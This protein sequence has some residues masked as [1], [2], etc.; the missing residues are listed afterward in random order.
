MSKQFTA[1]PFPEKSTEGFHL[2][3][4]FFGLVFLGWVIGGGRFQGFYIIPDFHP[5]FGPVFW[6]NAW[7]AYGLGALCVCG[8]LAGVFQK[9]RGIGHSIAM[10]GFLGLLLSD[11]IAYL[12]TH[13][14]V[15]LML[16]TS[17]ILTFKPK[18]VSIAK[19]MF[20]LILVLGIFRLGLDSLMA[21]N[22]D[23]SLTPHYPDILG[24]V[25]ILGY[26]F[27]WISKQ[28]RPEI[29]SAWLS[30]ALL[31]IPVFLFI[32][33]LLQGPLWIARTHYF[34]WQ[35]ASIPTTWQ[36]HITLTPTDEKPA[37]LVNSSSIFGPYTGRIACDPKI[38]NAYIAYV[39]QKAPTWW[40]LSIRKGIDD[41]FVSIG[42]GP[43]QRY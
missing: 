14:L 16:C 30:L 3:T 28:K 5:G 15:V 29:F 21:H 4:T 43:S 19:W 13:F 22:L 10:F 37:I 33:G 39:I 8:L 9:T 25:G 31:I 34:T 42:D 23:M 27:L 38:R 6:L 2:W 40:K 36:H 35:Y 20:P 7:M 11:K 12:Q 1:T 41:V 18:Q 32:D 26:G 24:S 17:L